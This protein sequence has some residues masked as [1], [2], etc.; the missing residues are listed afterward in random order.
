MKNVEVVNDR[1]I[2]ICKS[3]LAYKLFAQDAQPDKKS[4]HFVG[5]RYVRFAQENVDDSLMNQAQEML[6]QRESG[7]KEIRALW[8]MM[9]EWASSGHQETYERYG[10]KID[11]AHKESDV[12]QQGKEIALKGLQQ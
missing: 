11:R 1:G 12:Y 8:E 4:D 2:H 3:M 9:N 10:T 6:Q 7:N 5:D